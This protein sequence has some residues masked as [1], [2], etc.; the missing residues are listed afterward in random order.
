M[1]EHAKEKDILAPLLTIYILLFPV[2]PTGTSPSPQSVCC[3]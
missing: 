2:F 3:V 1:D